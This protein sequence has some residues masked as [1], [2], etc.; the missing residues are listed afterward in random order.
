MTAF[1][2]D[3]GANPFLLTG[4]LAGLLASV[5][6]GMIGPYVITRRIVF[7]AGAIAHIAIGGI[8]AAIFLVHRF[9]DRLAGLQPLHGATAVSILAAVVLA[10]VYQQAGERLDTIVGALWAT[11]MAVGV[12]LIKF[13]P[14]YQGELMSY[15]FGNIAYV[16]WDQLRQ[17]LVLDLIIVVAVALWHK[18]FFAVCLDAEQTE[19]QGIGVLRTHIV[20]LMLVA[21]TVIVL[22]QVV[23]L[24]L[25]IALVSLPAAAAARRITRLAS[26]I[27]VTIPLCAGLTTLPRIAVY[28]TRIS[29]EAAIVL[30]A[31]GVYLGAVTIEKWR[32]RNGAKDEAA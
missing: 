13:T 10:V 19:L 9:P 11:G 17:M 28:G 4:L 20:L 12:L 14:G 2:H 30:S 21:L 3:L 18:R 5:A 23:G 1:F 25:V 22:T 24:I 7:L 8:G 29:P 27:W 31:A 32:A 6:C 15:L 16:G 26:L